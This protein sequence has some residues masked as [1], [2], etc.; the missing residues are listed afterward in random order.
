MGLVSDNA[1]WTKQLKSY[2]YC[3]QSLVDIVDNE[4]ASR[5]IDG[6]QTFSRLC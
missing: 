3:A 4:G 2:T 5:L 6:W 1:C